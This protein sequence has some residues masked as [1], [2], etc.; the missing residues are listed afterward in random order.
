MK[1][2]LKLILLSSVIVLWGSA[3]QAQTCATQPTCAELG[4]TLTS[5][6]DCIGT[7]LK[8]P[9]DKTKYYCTTKTEALSKLSADI[10]TAAMPDYSK[11]LSR[12]NN[13]TYTAA[14]NGFITGYETHQSDAGGCWDCNTVDIDVNIDGVNVRISGGQTNWAYNSWSYPV[15]KGSTYRVSGGSRGKLGMS[16]FFVPTI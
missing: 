15:K 9:F 4:Y 5:T 7:V 13:V 6:T 3:A 11:R 1:N 8:C 14:T 2:Y 16:Y 12:S 10:V